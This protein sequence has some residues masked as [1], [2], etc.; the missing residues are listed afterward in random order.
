M[1][2]WDLLSVR[3]DFVLLAGGASFDVVG[4]PFLQPW[5]PVVGA[6]SLDRLVAPWVACRWFPVVVVQDFS[7]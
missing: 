2:Q 5:P 3:E 1:E 7:F 4:R 6:Y